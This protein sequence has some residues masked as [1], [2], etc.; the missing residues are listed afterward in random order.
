[1]LT[2]NKPI[3]VN[4]LLGYAPTIKW[5]SS[6]E[7]SV[8]YAAVA[9]FVAAGTSAIITHK[10]DIMIPAGA[11]ANMTIRETRNGVITTPTLTF[12]TNTSNPDYVIASKQYDNTDDV[13]IELLNPAGFIAYM[14]GYGVNESY[15]YSAGASAF[16]LQN[17]F[18]IGTSTQPYNDTYYSATDETTHAFASTDHITVK[19]TLERSF[20]H[21]SW[22]I[23]GAVYS[24]V[25]ENTN[26]MN[27]LTFPASLLNCGKNSITMSV[28]YTG[29]AADSLYTGYVWG[30]IYIPVNPHLRS[31]VIQ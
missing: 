14:T 1:M 8:T 23:H 13:R 25:A 15:I 22:L 24:G 2:S 18:T 27:T 6:M 5:W 16:N 4:H 30:V 31:R 7:Q 26:S 17:Y 29:A 20:T 9:P 12:Y 10:L 19:R 21:A 28:R 3:I 11:E